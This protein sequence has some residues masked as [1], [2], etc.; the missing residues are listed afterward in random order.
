LI[1]S[2]SWVLMVPY[3]PVP[4]PVHRSVL[5][6]QHSRSTMSAII[7]SI[8]S[9]PAAILVPFLALAILVIVF[10]RSSA[11]PPVN[12]KK[13]EYG[14]FKAADVAMHN[15]RD[16]LWIILRQNGVAKVYDVTSYVDEH[17][18]GDAILTNA[19]GDSSDEFFGPQHPPRVHDMIE[20][21]C[22]GTLLD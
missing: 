13:R 11:P 8:L 10:G 3:V 17:P 19:G 5:V 4:C 2:H 21:F 14:Q 16:D 12:T 22:I 9:N 7:D 20:D 15:H 18:G 1:A 6:Q